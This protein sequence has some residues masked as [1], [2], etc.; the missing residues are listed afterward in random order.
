MEGMN[1]R[2][3]RGD[4]RLNLNTVVKLCVCAYFTEMPTNYTFRK[5]TW[6]SYNN[7]NYHYNQIASRGA[8]DSNT[9]W[10]LIQETCG[11]HTV[12]IGSKQCADELGAHVVGHWEC[13]T[14]V[15]NANIMV[16][17]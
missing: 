10:D 11:V 2:C 6:Q 14:I 16:S 8:V 7:S 17:L 5:P 1:L 9:G 12:S 13:L 3:R 4:I 15:K